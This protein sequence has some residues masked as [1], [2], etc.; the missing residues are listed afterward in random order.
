MPFRSNIKMLT[1]WHV[2]HSE[3]INQCRK[4]L[5]K[6]L[7]TIFTLFSQFESEFSLRAIFSLYFTPSFSHY[8]I[9]SQNI[10][11]YFSFFFRNSS[12]YIMDGYYYSNGWP[13][14][15]DVPS[16]ESISYSSR[17]YTPEF[18]TDQVSYF[19]CSY[20]YSSFILKVDKIW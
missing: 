2:C 14:E 1:N 12:N 4:G 8:F 18:S 17:D 16:E 13:F 7:R 15:N 11:H 19:R 9:H 20:A 5:E 3:A 6:S 10:S